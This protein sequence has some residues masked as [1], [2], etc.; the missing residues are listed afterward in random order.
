MHIRHQVWVAIA[1]HTSAGIAERIDPLTRLVRLGVKMDFSRP[2][3]EQF[4]ATDY[5]AQIEEY[6]PRLNA[7][8]VLADAV[9]RQAVKIP[10]HIDRYVSTLENEPVPSLSKTL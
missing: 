3:R 2:V 7:E 1:L 10:E 8:R 6:V 5:A 9:V 4:G